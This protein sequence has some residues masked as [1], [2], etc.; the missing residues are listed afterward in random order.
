V[1]IIVTG[2]NSGGGKATATALAS[3]GHDVVIACRTMSK[4]H[5]AAA[6]MSGNVEVAEL[7]LADLASVRKFADSVDFV[8][9][10]VNNA[11]FS[12]F[13]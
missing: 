7:D 4:A 10:L 11:G 3:A 8:D 13:R 2:G 6:S 9:V 1:R 5:E 12:A